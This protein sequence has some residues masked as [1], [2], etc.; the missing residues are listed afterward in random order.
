MKRRLAILFSL[1][2]A[3]SSFLVACGGAGESAEATTDGKK[4]FNTTEPSEITTM[5]S[6]KAKDSSSSL[7]L[8]NTMEGL[9]R[10]GENDKLEAG[11]AEGDPVV[12]PDGL[13]YTFKIRDAKWSNG[14]TVKAHD[15]EYAWKRTLDPKTKSQYAF[16]LYDLK[17][18]KEANTGKVGLDQVGVK[19][20]DDKTL[21]V[22]LKR[23]VPYFQKLLTFYSF[24]P[25][26]K[27]AVEQYGDKYGLE[28]NT[29]VYN[30]PFVLSE[31]K[32]EQSY[33]L[34]KNEMYWDKDVV[35][36][37]EVNTKILKDTN[38]STNLYRTGKLHFSRLT[39]DNVMLFQNHEDFGIK[40]DPTI[41]YLRFNQKNDVLKN[42]KVR[43]AIDLVYDKKGIAEIILNNGSEPAKYWV[44]KNFAKDENG[45]DFRDINGDAWTGTRADAKQLWAEAKQEL[46]QDNIELRFLTSDTESSKKIA[47]FIKGELEKHLEGLTIEID[48]VPFKQKLELENNSDY[49]I[50]LVGWG[51]DYQDPMTFLDMF[52]QGHTQNNFHFTN[53]KYDE[54]IKKA[55]E[56][57]DNAVRWAAMAEAEKILADEAI[58][59]PIYQRATAYVLESNVK[60]LYMH[61]VGGEF[62]YKWVDIQ[63]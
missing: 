7:P 9:Y 43:K 44:P 2:L 59:S 52:V 28:A 30:G 4:V 37:D 26:N 40:Q 18:A 50:T 24:L 14:D 58:I 62:T 42:Q 54:L 27:N 47:E 55:Q 5:D 10:L 8:R 46:G 22:Q 23:P 63:Y 57:N 51:P 3:V 39:S 33:K 48:Q 35:K 31:W 45:K 41:F 34:T 17:N 56:S 21:Q 32:H 20:L 11:M 25:I 13:T 61:A 38:A 15:F 1:L 16:I 19:A 29:T 60:N 12:S 49:D 6:S 53:D 36:L